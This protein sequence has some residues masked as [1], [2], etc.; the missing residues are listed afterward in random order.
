[1]APKTPSQKR[2][3]PDLLP[4]SLPRKDRADVLPDDLRRTDQPDPPDSLPRVDEKISLGGRPAPDGGLAEH[5]IHDEDLDDRK[6]EDYEAEIAAADKQSWAEHP[7]GS[8]PP[9]DRL[10]KEHEPEG[11]AR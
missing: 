9:L 6:P 1:M 3:A 11:G 5:P 4:D 2:P 8:A 7:E 10:T